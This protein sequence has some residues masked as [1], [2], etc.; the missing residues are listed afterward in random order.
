M[1]RVTCQKWGPKDR[2]PQDFLSLILSTLSLQ[3]FIQ[4]TDPVFLP[5]DGRNDSAL[6]KQTSVAVSLPK[7]VGLS[8]LCSARFPFSDGAKDRG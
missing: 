4:T 6:G 2:C 5:K 1:E 7:G 8:S 3:Q